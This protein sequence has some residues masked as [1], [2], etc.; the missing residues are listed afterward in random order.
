[1]TQVGGAISSEP[2]YLR[3][4]KR[5]FFDL[6][7]VD[8]PG[9]TYENNLGPF[10]ENIYT[11]YIKKQNAIVLYVSP[12]VVDSTTG[13]SMT[14]IDR[15]DPGWTRTM[16]IITKIDFRSENFTYNYEKVNKGLGAFC[17]RNHTFK[18][19]ESNLSFE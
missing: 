8:L 6:T 10:I 12:A 13:Q 9:L 7:L 11:K 5:N 1:M 4:N 3:I 16:G 15:E 19:V 14:L 17:V 18:E 2:I